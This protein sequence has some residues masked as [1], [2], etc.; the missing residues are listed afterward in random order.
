MVCDPALRVLGGMLVAMRIRL[1][2]LYFGPDLSTIGKRW[3]KCRSIIRS[4]MAELTYP[5]LAMSSNP[6]VDFELKEIGGQNSILA[7]DG[8]TSL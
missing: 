3:K 1:V 5:F 8:L 2:D 6:T 4:T 7:P